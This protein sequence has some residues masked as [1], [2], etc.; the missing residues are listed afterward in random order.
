V[1]HGIAASEIA[2]GFGACSKDYRNGV[3]LQCEFTLPHQSGSEEL[4]VF[5]MALG[6]PATPGAGIVHH[7]TRNMLRSLTPTQLPGSAATIH[8]QPCRLVEDTPERN[9]P[10]LQ[11]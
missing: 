9:A 6:E 8:S 2:L 10:M 5:G 1:L 3:R 11:P 7:S 4:D